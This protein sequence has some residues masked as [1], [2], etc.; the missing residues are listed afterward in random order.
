MPY[1]TITFYFAHSKKNF[2]VVVK[3]RVWDRE[4]ILDYP[5]G[6]IVV[7][8]VLIKGRQQ[9]HPQHNMSDRI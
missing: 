3:L 7:T 8:K 4:I 9:D 6:P 5:S 2:V 1:E